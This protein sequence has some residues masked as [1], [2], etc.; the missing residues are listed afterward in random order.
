[1]EHPNFFA[2]MLLSCDGV[3]VRASRE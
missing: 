1:M 3:T 2:L